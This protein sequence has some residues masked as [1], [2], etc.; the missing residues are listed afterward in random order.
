[1]R[2]RPTPLVALLATG[3]SLPVHAQRIDTLA[4]G[5][6]LEGR[7][8]LAVGLE[9]PA[10][11]AVRGS[12]VY[13]ADRR[14]NRVY[15][16][17]DT[18]AL[19]V[20]AGNGG[21][22]FA[23]DGGP[24]RDATLRAPSAV[25]VDRDGN[26]FVSDTDSNRIRRIDAATGVIS[27]VAGGGH[28]ADRQGVG[29]P[30]TAALLFRPS[31][32]AV[33]GN[34]DLL[35]AGQG[36][37]ASVIVQRVSRGDG[38]IRSVD[39][40]R[41]GEFLAGS[42]GADDFGNL[43]APVAWYSSGVPKYEIRKVDPSGTLTVFATLDGPG[44][45]AIDPSS[46]FL[47]AMSGTKCLRIDLLTREI[48][49]HFERP[50][51][52]KPG[53][54][55]AADDDGRV[56]L[57][58]TQDVYMTYYPDERNQ[59]VV[60]RAGTTVPER[61]AGGRVPL[62]DGPA[63]EAV[64]GRISGFA[65]DV[66]GGWLVADGG[67][68]R[69]LKVKDGRVTTVAG[70][71]KP[72][73]DG[74]ENVPALS[75]SFSPSA[76]AVDRSGNIFVDDVTNARL[77]RVDAVTGL[78]R[79]I[80][81]VKTSLMAFDPGGA[82]HLVDNK[83]IKRLD[84]DG[85]FRYVAGSTQGVGTVPPEYDFCDVAGGGDGEVATNVELGCIQGIGFDRAGNL[86]LAEGTRHDEPDTR[87][88]LAFLR[89]VREGRLETLVGDATRQS[90]LDQEL[91]A[92]RGVF[93]P[94]GT[95]GILVA[96][97][98]RIRRI[99]L[100]TGA[101]ET[102]AGSEPRL[103][104]GFSGDGGLATAARLSSP[105]ALGL[106]PGG[107][108]MIADRD[109]G[110]LRIVVPPSAGGPCAGPTITRQPA[111]RTV[112]VSEDAVVS[113]TV[114]AGTGALRFQWF[115][116]ETGDVSRPVPG[117]TGPTLVVAGDQPS[118][119]YWVGIQDDCGTASSTAARITRT[120]SRANLSVSLAGRFQSTT[121][122]NQ[123][124]VVF[125]ATVRNLG[126][127]VAANVRLLR[128]VSPD[129]PVI[130]S[131]GRC[132]TE[133]CELGTL[134]EGAA[135]T[136][137]FATESPTSAWVRVE[138]DGADP[139]PDDDSAT[140]EPAYVFSGPRLTYQTRATP[141][142]VRAGETVVLTL[143]IWN[144]GSV[145][146][147][148]D[149]RRLFLP[150]DARLEPPPDS[151][152]PFRQGYVICSVRTPA[153]RSGESLVAF[154]LTLTPTRPGRLYTELGSVDVLP[155]D[156]PCTGAPPHL[157][158]PGGDI[159]AGRPVPVLA[160]DLFGR[161][162]SGRY[163]LQVA[164][165]L[166]FAPGS[167]LLDTTGPRRA[168]AFPSG[169]RPG[170]LFVRAAGVTGCGSGPFGEPS[171]IDVVTPLP[172][173]LLSLPAT[174]WNA[175]PGTTPPPLPVRVENTG[176]STL[177]VALRLE[178]GAFDLASR[179]ATI[180]PGASVN[181]LLT[182]R[183]GTTASSG[184]RADRL[185]VES[186]FDS[187]SVPI[188]LSVASL[189]AG[190]R[191]RF[192]APSIALDAGTSGAV[193]VR[194]AGT[195]PLTVVP[196]LGPGASWLD[197]EWSVLGEPLLPGEAR[198]LPVRVDGAR[199]EAADYP[200]PSSAVLTLSA[201]GGG[202]EDRASLEIRARAPRDGVT[203]VGHGA[204]ARDET[205]FVVPS[206][207]HKEGLGAT[208]VSDLFVT[209]SSPDPTSLELFL[210]PPGTDGR[211]AA[212][213][214]TVTVP[215]FRT[216]SLRDVVAESFGTSDL[217]GLLEVRSPAA[218]V[219]GSAPPPA[220]AAGSSVAA[221]GVLSLRSVTAGLPPGGP[222]T[223]YATAVPIVSTGAGTGEGAPPLVVAG[224][225]SDARTR[226]NV[227]LAE[228]AGASARVRLRMLDAEGGDRGSVEVDVP[229]AGQAQLPLP[230]SDVDGSLRVEPVSGHGRA[231]VLATRIDDRSGSFQAL[232][233]VPIGTPGAGLP[234][235]VPSIVHAPGAR[236]TFFTTDLAIANG[237]EVPARLRLV[238]R[239]SSPDGGPERETAADVTLPARGSLPV[240]RGRD[241][242][243]WLF[244][245]PADSA[246]VG[247]LR[248]E[249]E[250][251]AI[252]VRAVV[253]TPADPLDPSRGAKGADLA[254]FHARSPEAVGVG[255]T[256]VGAT[257]LALAIGLESGPRSR[258]NLVLT[259]V[260]GKTAT[261][262]AALRDALGNRLGEATW[263]LEPWQRTQVN[264]VFARAFRREDLRLDR[265]TLLLEA[266]GGEGRVVGLATVIDQE[267]ANPLVL[268]F[269]PPGPP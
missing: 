54:W 69:I 178:K 49:T 88:G 97:G 260:S 64:F 85:V 134:P 158:A 177:K 151:C 241:A 258:T 154:T 253:S 50:L 203:V 111:D 232:P 199:F 84:P 131:T 30:A 200:L 229:P 196:S 179:A 112:L 252:A 184:L 230:W 17:D 153:V 141:D 44:P 107:E 61:M 166:D 127:G 172:G 55:M 227:I 119:P 16:I 143:R 139:E 23:G 207:V 95:G 222:S 58:E 175:A 247:P 120:P 9:S 152:E 169:A 132:V 48:R 37:Y 11:I 140:A 150:S 102:L 19:R 216:L 121:P 245:L 193:T 187:T 182:A 122:P 262:R 180:E 63:L 8:A 108:L 40:L 65:Q 60:Y 114:R 72:T 66:D 192:D 15:R 189:A 144:Q 79:T 221:A 255:A 2:F 181:V 110:R 261:V 236:G 113:V 225:R 233:G 218:F 22:G 129:V 51:A 56:Y 83:R 149:A 124:P 38:R 191:P 98:H 138:S 226:V 75:A 263:T 73:W 123:G 209:S 237:A 52:Y 148:P 234:L 103:Q 62:P 3:L 76:L 74:Q 80:A 1:M 206:V 53:R 171:T 126:P 214:A 224:V 163:R 100:T 244:G 202:P 31:Q 161:D 101:Q 70:T 217:A 42:V 211:I 109:N 223:G 12:T 82:L 90:T 146:A 32:I 89:R 25:A 268:P 24:A 135:V 197:A 220:D 33:A 36:I 18:G 194:N 43:Y 250:T 165:S 204:T 45:V 176:G 157:S 142:P 159:P 136:V 186:S 137:T 215:A 28:P 198:L 212:R 174:P 125:D 91:L 188:F 5:G 67:H 117:A 249:G 190:G 162:A 219:G 235:V 118:S 160:S 213:R 47:Y 185:V 239:Y 20:V 68:S 77:F 128:T 201:A 39:A 228:T 130:S 155:V 10:G 156:A 6:S 41:S 231:A 167:L 173:L 210:T 27:T 259:E 205:A 4:G 86:I 248:V 106:G 264:D 57:L 115:R 257:P 168:V 105:S 246:T 269:T 251:G 7:T 99:D 46:R 133:A 238:Y 78:F 59:I 96:D 164:T 265:L 266:A 87:G 34:G 21:Y 26:L 13:F 256:G 267:S 195:A 170:S 29:G 242:I 81:G 93:Q 243:V 145:D 92:P 116:G 104:P 208:F 240:A 14:L 94:D 35:V 254:A 183:P 147:P 71:G